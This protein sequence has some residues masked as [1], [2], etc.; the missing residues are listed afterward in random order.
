ML[1]TPAAVPAPTAETTE[2]RTLA[3]AFH[4]DEETIDCRLTLTADH[5]AYELRVTPGCRNP[6]GGAIEGFEDAL[7]AFERQAAIERMLIGDGW[8]L[9]RFQS[10]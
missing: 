5:S 3:W 1:A 7:A 10:A 4:R 6:W 2:L 9:E 8:T